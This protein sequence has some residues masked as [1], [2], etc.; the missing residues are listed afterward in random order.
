MTKLYL[1]SPSIQL[2]QESIQKIGAHSTYYEALKLIFIVN[3]HG[4]W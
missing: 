3:K 4:Q 2:E 1:D